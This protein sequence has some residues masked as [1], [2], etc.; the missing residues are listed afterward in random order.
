MEGARIY[1]YKR[2]NEGWKSGKNRLYTKMEGDGTKTLGELISNVPSGV[3][4]ESWEKFVRYRRSPEGRVSH[5]LLM[6]TT[7]HCLYIEIL[8][9]PKL[10]YRWWYSVAKTAVLSK[11]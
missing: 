3:T 4:P 8:T 9:F 10:W 6:F 2:M 7:Y 5:Y 11:T 1:A